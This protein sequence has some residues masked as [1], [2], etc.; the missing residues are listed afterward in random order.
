MQFMQHDCVN[1]I[2]INKE[3]QRMDPTLLGV[4]SIILLLALILL[5]VPVAYALGGL[6]IIGMGLIVGFQGSFGHMASAAY[7]LSSQYAWAV[8]PLFVIIGSL[9]GQAGV[10]NEAFNAAR[11]WLGKLPGGLA[12]AT[13]VASGAFAACSGSTVANAAIFTPLALPEMLRSGYD[14]RLSVGCIAASGTFAAM[15]PPSLTM[16]VYCVITNEPIGQVLVGGIVPGV[17]TVVIYLTSIYLRVVR[18]PELAPALEERCSLGEKV[19]SLKGIWPIMSIFLVIIGGIY[20]GL[21]SPSSAG[22][23]GAA[24]TLIIVGFRKKLSLAVLKN[25][26]LE[27]GLIVSTLFLIIIGGSLF[28]RFW[29]LSGFVNTVSN[30]VTDLAIS[31]MLIIIMFM[32]LFILLGCFLDP[33]SMMVIT[34]PIVHPIVIELG[35]SGIWFGILMIKA[36][37]IAVI[38]PPIGFNAYIVHSAAA[39]KVHLEDVFAGLTPFVL[40]ELLTLA[41]LIMFPQI[42]LWLP[43]TMTF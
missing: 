41:I 31:P 11:K 23:A 28:G 6:G 7:G 43:Q 24:A 40:L 22:A 32:L 39:G 42:T 29:V 33:P 5:G 34:L 21:F 38:T 20:T 37:E 12:M 13:C 19:A 25:V 15:I 8:C 9:A 17:L 2:G 30:W 35:F 3:G 18:N 26:S 36:T 4:A 14:K 1:C 10:T 16:I 27:I